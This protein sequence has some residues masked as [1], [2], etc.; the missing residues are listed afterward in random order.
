MKISNIKKNHKE[1]NGF[2][3]V[4]LVIVIAG[5][6]TLGTFTVPN[7]LNSLK[8]NKAEQAKAMMNGYAA[9]CLNKFRS[10]SDT[11]DFMQN[12]VP[13]QLDDATLENLGYKMDP[14]QNKCSSLG[15][16][17][18]NENEKDLFGMAFMIDQEGRIIKTGSPSNNPKFL[19]SCTGWAGSN[20]GLSDEQKKE[21]ERL[22]NIAKRKT[23]C[24]SDHNS[25]LDEGSSGEYVSWDRESETCSRQVFAFEGIPVNSAEALEKAI[26]AKY[27]RVCRDWR[28][29]QME[30]NRISPNGDPETIKECVGVNY[31]FHSGDEFTTQ[32]GFD[33]KDN[34]VKVLACEENKRIAVISNTQGEYTYRPSPGPAPCGRVVWL[35]GDQ[36]FISE[37][38]YK[39]SSCGKSEDDNSEV[40]E[41]I[42][43]H[44]IGFVP[45][46]R[47][48]GTLKRNSPACR[49]R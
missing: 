9:D 36:E 30:S 26:I 49:C 31:W 25:W 43:A 48:G 18:K 4:E 23:E 17:P 28:K 45:S 15:I 12:A 6:A 21:F 24:I 42:P 39:A 10:S 47:C 1:N 33:N 29:D 11:S 2:T 27:G 34:T 38:S 5:L 8:E 22:A 46:K 3:L 32:A 7:V 41:K 13:D 19:N 20:C 16:K 14:D 40:E 37:D 44:C 35:C